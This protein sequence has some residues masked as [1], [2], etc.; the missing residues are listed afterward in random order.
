MFTTLIF[1]IHLVRCIFY[2]GDVKGGRE[3]QLGLT[4]TEEKCA[5]LVAKERPYAT[6]ATWQES[7]SKCWAEFGNNIEFTHNYRTCLFPT[8]G[9]Q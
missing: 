3:E 4:W 1:H 7:P 6:G 8:S 9:N 2:D 5:E